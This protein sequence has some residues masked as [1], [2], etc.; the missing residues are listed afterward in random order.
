MRPK[1]T[2]KRA[3]TELFLFITQ[4]VSK[5]SVL[6]Y[7]NA[8]QPHHGKYLQGLIITNSAWMAN[9][10]SFQDEYGFFI[11]KT[12]RL[13]FNIHTLLQDETYLV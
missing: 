6:G 1:V 3:R 12:S 11:I 8:M 4:N 7:Y 13:D 2:Q 9:S 5:F 10:P